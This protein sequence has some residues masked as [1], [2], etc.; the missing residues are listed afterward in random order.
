MSRH[1]TV[2]VYDTPQRSLDRKPL[3]RWVGR[4]IAFFLIAGVL[5][6]LGVIVVRAYLQ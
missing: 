1:A 2:D 6:F 3:V 5:A 4:A